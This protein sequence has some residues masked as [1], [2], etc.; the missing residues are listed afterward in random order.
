MPKLGR[1][2]YFGLFRYG[3]PSYPNSLSVFFSYRVDAYLIAF[4]VLDPATALGYY[5]LA[6]G[7]AESCSSSR[8]R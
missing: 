7:L 3:L 2:T 6:V 1:V 4:L 8:A 5:S